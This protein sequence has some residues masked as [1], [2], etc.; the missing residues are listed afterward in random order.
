VKIS[1]FTNGLLANGIILKGDVSLPLALEMAFLSGDPVG[2][3]EERVAAKVLT[4]F[5]W[6]RR[7]PVVKKKSR[8][9]RGDGAGN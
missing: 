1:L 6:V 5:P 2:G 8:L 3:A 4:V 9:R 7:G